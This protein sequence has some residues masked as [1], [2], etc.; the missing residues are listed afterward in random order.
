MSALPKV[1]VCVPVRNG[2]RTIARTLDSIL[3]QDYAN[4]EIIVS[5]N[6]STDETAKIVHN[7][8]GQGV[9]YYSNSQ[10]EA[11]GESNWNYILSL[12]QGPLIALYHADDIY[13]STMLRRQAEFLQ[14]HPKSSAVFTMTQTIDEQDCPIRMGDL[15]LPRELRG[16]D[17]F[18]FSEFFNAVLKYHTFT[19]VPTMMTRKPVIEKVG[20]F[21]FQMFGSASDIDLYLRMARQWGEIGIID[22]PLH[23]YRIGEF[24]GSAVIAKNR[25]E[26]PD[27]YR[28]IDA[29][30][31]DSN[32]MKV[33]YAQS[34]AFYEMYRA[35]DHVICAQNLLAKRRT[36]EA[37]EHLV[38]VLHMRHFMT[39]L[40][41][42]G[43]LAR[44]LAGIGLWIAIGLG[45]GTFL[46]QQVSRAYACR[47]SW[48]RK[49]IK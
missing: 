41:R 37:R 18:E 32:E 45:F 5:D 15:R 35:A 21:R 31:N 22:E 27:F 6:G 36:S 7:Y 38:E 43:V 30:L 34:L 20:N 44:L 23:K 1:T 10:I 49:E 3:A 25:T 39:A 47:N 17:F 13:T 40:R 29:H 9:R 19:Y 11:F 2:A 26:L 14:V 16:R 12:A 42:P 28:A 48:Q 46:G 33:V 4:F 24:Q 8:A